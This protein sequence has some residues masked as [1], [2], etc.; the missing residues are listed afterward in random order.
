MT[1]QTACEPRVSE[2]A[3]SHD[4][5]HYRRTPYTSTESDEVFP[6]TE[7]SFD[8]R[9]L[10]WSFLHM[11]KTP[12]KLGQSYEIASLHRA[13]MRLHHRPNLPDPNCDAAPNRCRL[14]YVRVLF[15]KHSFTPVTGVVNAMRFSEVFVGHALGFPDP[16]FWLRGNR[17]SLPE[18]RQPLGLAPCSLSICIGTSSICIDRTNTPF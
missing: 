3:A 9:S 11:F 18:L 2:S 1:S 14:H 5:K 6:R 17:S 10:Q 7:S 4:A 8:S 12:C 13:S 15:E 16:D